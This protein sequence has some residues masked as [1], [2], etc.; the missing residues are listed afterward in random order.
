M[1]IDL[2]DEGN[3]AKK[4]LND[5]WDLSCHGNEETESSQRYLVLLVLH[6]LAVVQVLC[7]PHKE[8]TVTQWGAGMAEHGLGQKVRGQMEFWVIGLRPCANVCHVSCLQAGVWKSVSRL[9]L[10][11][12]CQDQKRQGICKLTC[13]RVCGPLVFACRQPFIQPEFKQMYGEKHLYDPMLCSFLCLHLEQ[14]LSHQI[15]SGLCCTMVLSTTQKEA[16][17]F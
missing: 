13:Q 14:T 12:S 6:S 7:C 2:I 16:K 11:Q 1:I 15:N 4:T 10:V 5:S 3:A 8:V 9:L 17:E